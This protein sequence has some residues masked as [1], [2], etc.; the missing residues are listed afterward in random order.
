MSSN[1][2][3]SFRFIEDIRYIDLWQPI[4]ASLNPPTL[5]TLPVN[6][7]LDEKNLIAIT[8]A[9]VELQRIIGLIK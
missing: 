7:K 1:C 3:K 8:E 6:P 5:S 4:C 2:F 9:D